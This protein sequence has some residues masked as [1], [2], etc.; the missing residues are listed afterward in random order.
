MNLVVGEHCLQAVCISPVSM[1]RFSLLLQ[2]LVSYA[3]QVRMK[4][5]YI[6]TT[7]HKEADII[8]KIKR[9]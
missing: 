8:L 4:P 1:W 5:V 3:C 2:L 9:K 6:I 7:S